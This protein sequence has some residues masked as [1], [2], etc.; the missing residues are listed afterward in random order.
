[1]KVRLL[2]DIND[3][4]TEKSHKFLDIN[5]KDPVWI[6]RSLVYHI[7]RDKPDTQGLRVC[8]AEVE[9]WFAEREEL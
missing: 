8:V 6:P 4:G 7:S 3:T 1:M 9:D 5:T 2:Q